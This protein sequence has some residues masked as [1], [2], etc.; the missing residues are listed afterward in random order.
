MVSFSAA[1]IFLFYFTARLETTGPGG[2][3][4]RNRTAGLIFCHQDPAVPFFLYC[5]TSGRCVSFF[6]HFIAPPGLFL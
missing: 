5:Y 6:L 1:P 3:E 2:T 4:E